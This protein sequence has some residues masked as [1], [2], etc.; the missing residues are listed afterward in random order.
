MPTVR[1]RVQK[2]RPRNQPTHK[3]DGVMKARCHKFGSI[4]RCEC[5]L[6]WPNNT[7][8]CIST[9]TVPVYLVSIKLASRQVIEGGPEPVVAFLTGGC[10]L[11][12]NAP[13]IG[14]NTTQSEIRQFRRRG[15]SSG[16]EVDDARK[17]VFPAGLLRLIVLTRTL[18][19]VG[20]VRSPGLV[21]VHQLVG[22]HGY[23]FWAQAIHNLCQ[24]AHFP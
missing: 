20:R 4:W 18:S 22:A 6:P 24:H 2:Q 11:P 1:K 5:A 9:M 7:A 10:A 21:Q 16:V 13:R 23:V 17:S 19:A 14:S 15:S 3:N 8:K 12:V